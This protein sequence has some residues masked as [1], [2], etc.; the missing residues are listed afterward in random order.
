MSSLDGSAVVSLLKLVSSLDGSAVLSLLKLVLFPAVVGVDIC[1]ISVE[2]NIVEGMSHY[3][4]CVSNSTRCFSRGVRSS[5]L[6]SLHQQKC[7]HDCQQLLSCVL[8][9]GHVILGC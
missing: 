1:L 8:Q 6:Q 5:A 3:A 4:R 2:E 7:S 9:I